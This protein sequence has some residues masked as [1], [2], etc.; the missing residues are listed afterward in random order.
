MESYL[1]TDLT[2]MSQYRF[3][4]IPVTRAGLPSAVELEKNFPWTPYQV[5]F[6]DVTKLNVR[7][8]TPIVTYEQVQINF[9]YNQALSR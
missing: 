3:R 4:V 9:S 7:I 5:T 6:D 8:P 2:L 1:S